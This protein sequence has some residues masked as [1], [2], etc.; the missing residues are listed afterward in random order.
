MYILSDSGSRIV[1]AEDDAQVAKLTQQRERAAGRGLAWS[2]STVEPDGE[3]VL[4]LDDLQALGA[5]HLAE[6]PTAVD[7]S[8]GR[9]D[10]RAPGHAHLHLGHDRAA[11]GRRAAAPLLDLHR[12]RGHDAGPAV[13]P[14]TCSTCGC[15]C[16]TPSA[17]CCRRSSCRSASRPPSTAASTRSSRT[18][19][20]S[21]RP[22]W[23]GP[24]GSSR[25]CT[26]RSCRPSRRRAASRAR[27]STGPS[28]SGDRVGA[29]PA[30]RHRAGPAAAGCSTPSPTGWCCRQDPRP[31]R[32][33]DP[34]P[35]LRQRGPV[36][37][38]WPTG[39]TP[40]GCR[41]S[42]ATALTETS[43]G[44]CI[45]R[46]DDLQFGVVGPPLAGHRDQAGRRTARSSSGVPG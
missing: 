21:G 32:R 17:R 16:R 46:P 13:G 8:R 1:F 45:T 20:W 11:Q 38:T 14:T 6:H 18:S 42:R 28:A 24:R 10:L 31:A 23:P 22:S 9:G 30:A 7:D 36:A 33:P 25:R 41:S 37:R 4:S 3:W 12:R 15:R 34:L 44:A 26:P 29:G 19:P 35:R 40:P 39:S 27:C 43:A 5:R 2:P